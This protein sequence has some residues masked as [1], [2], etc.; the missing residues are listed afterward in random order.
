MGQTQLRT[1]KTPQHSYP[2]AQNPSQASQEAVILA[3]NLELWSVESGQLGNYNASLPG[4][5]FLICKTVL[6]IESL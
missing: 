4:L 6:V 1:P 5:Y 3:E 2:H